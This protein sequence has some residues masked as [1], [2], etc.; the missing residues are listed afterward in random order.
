[1]VSCLTGSI[2]AINW[3]L[4]SIMQIGIHLSQVISS[5]TSRTG[6]RSLSGQISNKRR[7]IYPTPRISRVSLRFLALSC[8]CLVQSVAVASIVGDSQSGRVPATTASPKT[9]ASPSIMPSATSDNYVLGVGDLIRIQVYGEPDL[10]MRLRLET[11]GT[12]SYPFLGE[13][14]VVGKSVAYVRQE[15]MSGLAN[16]YLKNPE[17]QVIVEEYRPFYVNGE[18]RK[19]G[20]YPYIPG[21]TVQQA[22]ALAG[23]ITDRASTSK[24]YLIRENDPRSV[25]THV[26]LNSKVGPGDTLI[27][28]EGLF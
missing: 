11:K 15:I 18:V 26:T 21:L 8:L 16:G 14:P 22:L 2:G 9:T 6:F 17:V 19:P 12:I 3:L 28:K 25:S 7:P 13:I 23:G 10:T 27:I 5:I 4:S 1:M 24:I 20:G